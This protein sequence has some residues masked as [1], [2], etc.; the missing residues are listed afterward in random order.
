MKNNMRNICTCTQIW[1]TLSVLTTRRM[2]I[3]N[4]TRVSFCNQPKA[5]YLATSQESRRYVV[6]FRFV[7]AGI[8]LRQ[9]S[10]RYILASPGYA[11]GTIAVN[12]T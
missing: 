10:L 6:A 5:H 1:T 8:W 12:V 9:E 3:A 4:G 7:A 2:A 11:P